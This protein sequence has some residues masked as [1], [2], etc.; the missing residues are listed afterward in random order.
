MAPWR[1]VRCSEA[2]TR[3]RRIGDELSATR[4][5]TV[6]DASMRVGGGGPSFAGGVVAIGPS[7]SELF[8]RVAVA[9]GL[10]AAIG[11]ERELRE[12]AAGLR[13]HALVALG[14]AAFTVAGYAVLQTPDL[15]QLR[16]DIGRIA[17]QVATGI[18]FI[19]AG[20]IVLQENRVRGLTTAADLWAVAGIGVLAGLGLLLVA[21]ATAG[22][23]LV[24]VAGARVLDLAA[25]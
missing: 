25:R 18:G 1:T 21:A 24:I 4:D 8:A 11:I 12:K 5:A 6:S 7:E 3:V 10:G 17:A 19:G 23:V 22:L 13:T 14:A 16:P 9:A 20:V 15:A 2:A